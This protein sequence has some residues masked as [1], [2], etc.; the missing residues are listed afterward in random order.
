[1]PLSILWL[2]SAC[3]P[4]GFAHLGPHSANAIPHLP[5]CAVQGHCRQ[6]RGPPPRCLQRPR[7]LKPD[8]IYSVL[9]RVPA[10][11]YFFNRKAPAGKFPFASASLL[12]TTHCSKESLHAHRPP[13]SQTEQRCG[14]IHP[15]VYI[16][17]CRDI[18]FSI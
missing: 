7:A 3:V 13:P 2:I 17:F 12:S 5:L 14:Y 10:F 6:L 9:D 18:S 15:E 4:Q 8:V 11:Q 1:M 16:A